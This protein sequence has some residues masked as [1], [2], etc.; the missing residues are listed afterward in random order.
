MKKIVLTA[1]TLAV[2]AGACALLIHQNMVQDEKFCAI[3]EQNDMFDGETV[4]MLWHWR[5]DGFPSARFRS[6]YD[7]KV[8]NLPGWRP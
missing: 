1:L 4:D 2:I 6:L 8:K 3:M 7:E 5:T